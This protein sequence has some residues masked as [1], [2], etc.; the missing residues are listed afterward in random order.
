M[1]NMISSLLNRANKCRLACSLKLM[2]AVSF[3]YAIHISIS[4]QTE[5][6]PYPF[7]LLV[8]LVGVIAILAV[9][10]HTN[11]QLSK[12]EKEEGID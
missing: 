1:T 11:C 8:A 3:Y 7:V 12:V 4:H 10:S 9:E 6:S 5:V 2:L